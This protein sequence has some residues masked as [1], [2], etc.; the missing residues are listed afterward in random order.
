MILSILSCVYWSSICIL[1]KNVCLG[2]LLTFLLSCLFF[3][4]MSYMGCLYILEIN[5]LSFASVA[6]IF[7]HSKDCLDYSFL[8]YEKFSSLIRSHLYIF[9]LFSINLEDRLNMTL[10]EYTAYVFF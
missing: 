4:I 3:L 1:W 2:L 9:V 6:M 7:F 5:S 8:Y 10:Q